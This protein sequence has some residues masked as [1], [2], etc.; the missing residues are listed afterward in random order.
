MTVLHIYVS[1][2]NSATLSHSRRNAADAESEGVA[3]AA[4]RGG[5]WAGPGGW[6]A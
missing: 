1:C 4:G 2:A 5:Q 6:Q 3:A